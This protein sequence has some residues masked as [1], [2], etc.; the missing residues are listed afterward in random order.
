MMKLGQKSGSEMG[1]KVGRSCS[2]GQVRLSPKSNGFK[3]GPFSPYCDAFLQWQIPNLKPQAVTP[4]PKQ[5]LYEG[6]KGEW[7]AGV[8]RDLQHHWNDTLSLLGCHCHKYLQQPKSAH[9]GPDGLR[10]ER[11][12]LLPRT[13][14]PLVPWRFCVKDLTRQSAE[15]TPLPPML[16][17]RSFPFLGLHFFEWKTWCLTIKPSKEL[18]RL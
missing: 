16:Q 2:Y 15:Q 18:F 14:W 10:Q 3:A 12:C 17:T 11:L 9:P 8:A 13:P 1:Q 6:S 7:G 4:W 5:D